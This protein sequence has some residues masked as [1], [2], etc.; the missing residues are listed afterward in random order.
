MNRKK[1][2][3]VSHLPAR[4]VKGNVWYIVFYQIDPIDNQ[5]KRFRNTFDL[6]RIKCLKQRVD[7][8]RKL[9]MEINERLPYG[10]PW[11]VG[12][13]SKKMSKSLREAMELALKHSNT[14]NKSTSRMYKSVSKYLMEWAETNLLDEIDV[15]EFSKSMFLDFLDSLK[16]TNRSKNV[17]VGVLKALFNHL[18]EREYIIMN[19]AD[20]IKKLK[21]EPKKRRDLN[22]YELKAIIEELRSDIKLEGFLIA[23][24][25]IY[26]MFIRPAELARLKIEHIHLDKGVIILTEDMTKNRRNAVVSIPDEF[27]HW[28]RK[29]GNFNFPKKHFVFS[30]LFIP[31]P[32]PISPLA[33]NSKFGYIL[34]RLY[35]RKQLKNIDGLSIYSLKDTGNRDLRK[36]LTDIVDLMRHN[37]HSDLKTTMRYNQDGQNERIEGVVNW[38]PGLLD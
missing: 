16:I 9:I 15:S 11:D 8:A 21:E 17:Y 3:L 18:L 4:L 28:L 38:R 32:E 25:F 5:R 1:K 24:M 29:H 23:C 30:K 14:G 33:F 26:Y 2:M 27:L 37:R 19:P 10:Y 22:E 7:H 13:A 20:G 31:G 36:N 12:Y 34:K 6:N 35:K